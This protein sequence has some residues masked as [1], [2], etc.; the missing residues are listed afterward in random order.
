MDRIT[1]RSAPDEV[2]RGARPIASSTSPVALMNMAG[3][4]KNSGDYQANGGL[5]IDHDDISHSSHG[6]NLRKGL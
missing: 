3:A 4:F 6:N 1:H 2:F 5:G